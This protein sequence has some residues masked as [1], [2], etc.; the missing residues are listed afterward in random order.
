[1]TTESDEVKLQLIKEE[2]GDVITTI[3]TM[4]TTY[5]AMGAQ[6]LLLSGE[7]GDGP[8]KL[9]ILAIKANAELFSNLIKCVDRIA[10]N[11]GM[12]FINDLPKNQEELSEL[13]KELIKEYEIE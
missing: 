6:E 12:E 2:I 4:I 11:F 8:E 10:A 1:M 5:T 3:K 7:I 13:Q 9:Y